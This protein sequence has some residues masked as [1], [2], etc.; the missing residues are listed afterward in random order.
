MMCHGDRGLPVLA[1]LCHIFRVSNFFFSPCGTPP[2]VRCGIP[3]PPP[4]DLMG[5]NMCLL[6]SNWHG[7]H[8]REVSRS[9]AKRMIAKPPLTY[10]GDETDD[11]SDLCLAHNPP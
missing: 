10:S 1:V 3:V 6:E 4:R 9:P 7:Q 8:A 2:D 11:S 5:L